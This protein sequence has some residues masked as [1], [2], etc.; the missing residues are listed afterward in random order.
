MR[1]VADTNTVVSGLLWQGPPRQIIDLAREGA[2]TL[3]TSITLLAEL[4]VDPMRTRRY[5]LLG[6]G[7]AA[8]VATAVVTTMKL[9]GNSADNA[10]LCKGAERH[11]AG[12][13][14]PQVKQAVR[15]AFD[16]TDKPFKA[17]AFAAIEST[18]DKYT[19]EWTAAVTESCEA[20]NISA[21]QTADVQS[22]RQE[23]FDQRLAVV[24]SFTGLLANADDML[25][26]KASN[27]ALALE[28]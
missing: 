20:T 8:I 6:A 25:V 5:A 24:R 14:D 18:L 23:C 26:A 22:L 21:V 17:K 13:W 28:R 7:G 16:K 11:L 1:I 9:S 4:A 3:H 15:A 12:V 2:I 19:R 27:A 10:M